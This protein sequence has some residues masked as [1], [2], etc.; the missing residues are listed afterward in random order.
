MDKRGL[1]WVF[2]SVAVSVLLLGS[3]LGGVTRAAEPIKIGA[4]IATTGKYG[5]TAKYVL[6]G[7]Q[8]WAHQV[9]Q[10]GGLLG[11]PV[12][13]IV[14]DDKSEPATSAKLFEQL[15]TVDK[16]DLVLSPYSS[17]VTSKVAPVTEQYGY[18]MLAAGAASTKIWQQGS[19]YIFKMI[20]PAE[21]V[22]EGAIDLAA[23]RG[24]KTV[25]MLA[26]N[27]LFP[28]SSA[29]GAK[30]ILKQRGM[31]LASCAKRCL[32]Q[33]AAPWRP[34]SSLWCAARSWPGGRHGLNGGG[35]GQK[36]AL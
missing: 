16:V 27:S 2:V 10:R 11:R 18:P 34:A 13:L 15:I 30:E 32:E 35:A 24:L 5:S 14:L 33:C 22:L 26:V 36:R 31:E 3:V 12:E 28:K 19:R 6:E 17:A 25:A 1:T 9:N 4:A 29:A 7:F 23:T 8:L 20:P 21:I